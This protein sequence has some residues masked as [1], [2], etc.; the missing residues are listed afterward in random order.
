MFALDPMCTS[1]RSLPER[2]FEDREGVGRFATFRHRWM[3]LNHITRGE[4]SM[5]LVCGG[6][7]ELH[8]SGRGVEDLP[9]R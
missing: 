8:C 1:L 7:I 3:H 4:A 9:S 6:C 2:W 5:A